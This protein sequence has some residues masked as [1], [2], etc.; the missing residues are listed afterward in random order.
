MHKNKILDLIGR[1]EELFVNDIN[2][3]DT[4]LKKIVSASSFL[5]IGGAGSIGQ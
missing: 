1:S 3:Y 5:D 4:R 2:K